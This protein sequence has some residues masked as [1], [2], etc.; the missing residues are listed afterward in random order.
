MDDLS[1]IKDLL[2]EICNKKHE[3]HFD[4]NIESIKNFSIVIDNIFDKSKQC[5]RCNQINPYLKFTGTLIYINKS[6]KSFKYNESYIQYMHRILR[7]PIIFSYYAY[8]IIC[9]NIDCEIYRNNPHV[10]IYGPNSKL[11]DKLVSLYELTMFYRPTLYYLVI[12][13]IINRNRNRFN[14]YNDKFFIKLKETLPQDIFIN[15]KY[16]L[17]TFYEHFLEF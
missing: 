10:L 17:E 9:N 3:L 5:T 1:K 8:I 7:R 11:F 14:I 13:K 2:Q 4:Y 12:R 15:I 16:H 6:F